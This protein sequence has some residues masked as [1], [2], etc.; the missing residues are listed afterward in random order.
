MVI[1]SFPAWLAIKY[2]NVL[3]G[4]HCIYSDMVLV[5][6]SVMNP[7]VDKKC[8]IV[9][10][11]ELLWYERVEPTAVSLCTGTLSLV[12]FAGIGYIFYAF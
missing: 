7:S 5:P 11:D 3:V 10:S 6:F 9:K 12:L 8:D 4:M 1:S 2:F